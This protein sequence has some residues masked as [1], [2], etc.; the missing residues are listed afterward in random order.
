MSLAGSP[1]IWPL[2]VEERKSKGECVYV[3]M[4]GNGN[5]KEGYVKKKTVQR[6]STKPKG[7]HRPKGKAAEDE[8]ANPVVV[9]EERDKLKDLLGLDLTPAET[10]PPKTGI[11]SALP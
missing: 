7:G 1:S 5:G 11:A 9:V 6:I 4:Y 3:D 8:K 10:G 2:W